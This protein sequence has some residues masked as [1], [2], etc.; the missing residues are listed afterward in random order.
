MDP[1]ACAAHQR[2]SVAAAGE[3]EVE[4]R[5]LGLAESAQ[6]QRSPPRRLVLSAEPAVHG[7]GHVADQRLCDNR[8]E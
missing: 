1:F 8:T 7:H 5:I 4:A 6:Q 2:G 3:N